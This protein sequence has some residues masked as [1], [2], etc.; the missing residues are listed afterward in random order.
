MFSAAPAPLKSSVRVQPVPRRR[1]CR[2]P[3][4]SGTFV[5]AA[6]Q[7]GVVAAIAV[8]EVVLG[9]AE[10]QIVA[11]AAA[12]R[13]VPGAAL[14]VS[15]VSAAS[16]M[17]PATVSSPPSAWT[18]SS[19]S[20]RGRSTCSPSSSPRGCAQQQRPV[21][22]IV[23]PRRAAHGDASAPLQ[24]V[25]Q[26]L[27]AS[28]SPFVTRTSADRPDTRI[29]APS[30]SIWARS[31]AAVPLTVTASGWPSPALPMSASARLASTSSRSVPRTSLTR[32]VRHHPA[33][34]DRS[35]RRRRDP[36]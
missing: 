32:T 16:P 5:A 25:D 33:R 24:R 13:V 20:R 26:H 19:S 22:V 17:L 6:E 2:H 14:T 21:I 29:A 36:S 3:D 31:L 18:T 12:D 1:R 28:R 23:G 11:V 27:V 4:P 7:T 35:A 8:D 15:S 9:A 10:Q 30:W 34:S